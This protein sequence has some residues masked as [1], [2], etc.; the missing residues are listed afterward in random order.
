[1]GKRRQDCTNILLP[2]TPMRLLA[3]AWAIVFPPVRL[4]SS[5]SVLKTGARGNRGALGGRRRFIRIGEV[6][7]QGRAPQKVNANE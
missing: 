3:L 6:Q 2:A 5:G 4:I 1:M 7:H